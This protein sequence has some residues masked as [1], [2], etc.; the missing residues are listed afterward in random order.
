M[1]E[2]GPLELPDR[3]LWFKNGVLHRSDGPA[4]EFKSGRK[5]WF[6]NGKEVTE[7]DAIDQRQEME[8]RALEL[9]DKLLEHQYDDV[10]VDH[11]VTVGH[12]LPPFKKA[13]DK[14]D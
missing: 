1:F 12:A 7:Q 11:I 6:L 5:F 13:P 3:T 8:R 9:S 14:Q 4:V 10:T 2:D